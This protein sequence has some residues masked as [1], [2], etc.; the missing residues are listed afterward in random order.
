[1]SEKE[2]HWWNSKVSAVWLL[3]TQLGVFYGGRRYMFS[4]WLVQENNET[5][6]N[7]IMQKIETTRNRD[8]MNISIL[9]NRWRFLEM[10]LASV[11]RRN[12]Q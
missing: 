11:M 8:A 4:K 2:N 5:N 12:C 3:E 9:V 1:V 6:G 7:N 10:Q